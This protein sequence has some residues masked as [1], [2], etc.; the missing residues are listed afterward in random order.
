MRPSLEPEVWRVVEY[1]RLRAVAV[2][3]KSSHGLSPGALMLKMLLYIII[4]IIINRRSGMPPTV[5]RP[6]LG[7]CNQCDR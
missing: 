7:V 1:L 5:I 3:R 6:G 4:I 2:A